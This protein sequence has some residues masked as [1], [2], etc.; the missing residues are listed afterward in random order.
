MESMATA[1]PPGLLFETT[2]EVVRLTLNR[3]EKRNALSHA[4]LTE[5]EVALSRIAAEGAARVVVLAA[6]GPVFCSGHDLGE[7]PGR[8]EA[9]YRDAILAASPLTVRL[10]KAA[11]Y[12]QLALDEAA[13]YAE[14]TQ[15]MTDNATRRDAQEGMCAFL[16][17][18]RPTWRGE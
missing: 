5:L 12:D 18:R 13:A 11:F 8:S 2:G 16:E 14:A 10:G 15:V 9:E 17:K 3:P 6:S 7:M 1:A 4:L